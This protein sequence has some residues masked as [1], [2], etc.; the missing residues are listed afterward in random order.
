M[1]A[2]DILGR[3]GEL[4]K[5]FNVIDEKLKQQSDEISL[6]RKDNAEFRKEVSRLT[7]RVAVLE[8]GRRTVAAEVKLA[9]TE[10]I[11]A[12]ELQQVKAERD[13]LKAA[14]SASTPKQISS[15][16]NED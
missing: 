12:R 5:L 14:R 1:N 9:L 16:S 4:Y 7:E 2:L 11:S 3:I 6:L 15:T 8:E 10:A 13:E